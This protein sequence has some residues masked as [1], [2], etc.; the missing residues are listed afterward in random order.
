MAPMMALEAMPTGE[1]ILA[2]FNTAARIITILAVLVGAIVWVVTM[3]KK[4]KAPHETLEARVAANEAKIKV[5]A[6]HLDNDN[7]R[8]QEQEEVNRLLLRSVL[9]MQS[10][11]LDGN[12]TN[13]MK[14]CRDDINQYL[15]NR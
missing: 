2:M 9:N 4:L 6:Q 11:M 3:V 13:E 5:N 15:L 8:F 1:E 7:K 10:H 12:H 14:Q